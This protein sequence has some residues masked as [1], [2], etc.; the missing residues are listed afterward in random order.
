[1]ITSAPGEDRDVL[2][3]ALAA[4]TEARRLDRNGRERATQLVD[5]DGGERLAL[6]VLGHDQQRSTGLDDLLEHG[7]EVLDGPDLLVRDQDVGSSS[8]ASMRSGSV[9]M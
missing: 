1:M 4:V 8:T 3:H 7:Q 9:I 2:Q 6:D 5:D